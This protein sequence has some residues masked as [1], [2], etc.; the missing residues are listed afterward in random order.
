[1]QIALNYSVAHNSIKTRKASQV[2]CY[3]QS[4]GSQ[5]RTQK[6]ASAEKEPSEER[7]LTLPKNYQS[8]K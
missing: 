2:I 8:T 3:E 4:T 7:T 5:T 1:M 6:N